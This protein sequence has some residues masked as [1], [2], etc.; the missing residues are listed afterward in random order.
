MSG[1]V[2]ITTPRL[3]LR[4]GAAPTDA[5]ALH[6]IFS[7]PAVM[8]YWSTLPHTTLAQTSDWLAKMVAGEQNGVTEFVICLRRRMRT[9]TTRETPPPPSPPPLTEI[10]TECF[11]EA[12]SRQSPSETK[13]PVIARSPMAEETRHPD[14][15][16]EV[17]GKIGIWRGTE[18]GFLLHSAYWRCGLMREAMETLLSYYFSP[19]P[20]QEEEEKERE[21]REEEEGVGGGGGGIGG[22]GLDVVTADTDPRNVAT[23]AFLHALGFEVTGRE[24][25][26]WWVG[27]YDGG[28]SGG[29][30]EE[31]SD[32]G[33]G[34]EGGEW[35]DSVYL[36]LRREVWLSMMEERERE[37][38]KK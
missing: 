36:A 3:L 15:S 35:V 22:R 25:R 8:R 16:G 2:I 23:L 5:P 29:A 32:G 20:E 7:D 9:R 33:K 11:A 28:G 14:D 10:P 17:I 30:V 38:E 26:T 6:A 34:G 4:G 12:D 24:S 21:E 31:G 27:P 13:R 19:V 1:K 18:I 37:R